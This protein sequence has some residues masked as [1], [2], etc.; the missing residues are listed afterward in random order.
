MDTQAQAEVTQNEFLPGSL[1][2]YG[3]HGK[4]NVACTETRTMGGKQIRFYKLEIK[5]SA[6]SRSSRQDPAIWVPVTTAKDLGLRTPMNREEA[7]EAV[8]ILS[9]REYYFKI[10]DPWSTVQ[11]QLEVLIRVEGGIGLAKAASYLY[12]L[13][14]RQV[15]PTTEVTKFQEAVQKLLFR[16]L[17]E[18]LGEHIRDLE[19]KITKAFR[20]KLIPDN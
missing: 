15:V 3:M 1:V 13:K 10:N 14:R 20:A 4:C 9:S 11:P 5:K 2:I 6:F 16:E 8:R 7:E 12:V 18:A 19:V 17:S